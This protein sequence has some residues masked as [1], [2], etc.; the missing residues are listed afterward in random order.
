MTLSETFI[1]RPVATTLL[2]IGVVLSGLAAFYLLPVAPLPQVDFPTVVVNVSLP[3][4]GPDTMAATVATPLERTLG[5]I[6][7]ITEMT[8]V[9]TL[10]STN[11][12]LQF[13]LSRNIDG[14]ARDVQ[15][16]INAARALLPTGLPKNPIYR[17]VNPAD[18]PVMVL[19]LTSATMTQGELYDVA[20]TILAQKISQ[21]NGVG[22]VTV[23]GSA[24][25]AVRVELNPRA[26]NKYGISL[27]QARTSIAATNPNRPKGYLEDDK[28]HWQI[29]ANDQANRAKD[30]MPLVISYH[31]GSPVRLSDVGTAVDSVQDIRNAGSSNGVPAII[32]LVFKQP[33][34]NI[35]ET[36]DNVNKMLPGLRASIPRAV[37]L[38]V[39]MER[40]TTIK[41]ALRDVESNLLVSIF[42]VVL[43]VLVFLRKISSTIIP[44][45]AVP[46]SLI[47]TFGI[48][49]L[50]G[51]SLDNLSLMAIT[52]ATGFVVDDA[53][54]V[55]ENIS[56]HVESGMDTMKAA[57]LGA[58]EV[59]FT[60]VSMSLSL[61]A[62]FIP[63]LFMGG[64][65]GRLFREFA[66]SLSAAILVSLTVSLTLTPMMCAR[67][68][69]RESGEKHGRLY[70]LSERSFNYLYEHY[71]TTL[72]WALSHSRFIMLLLFCTIILN[73]YLYIIVP[74]SF[75]PQQDTGRIIGSIKADQ[76]ISFAAMKKKMDDF[77]R[78]IRQDPAASNVVGIVGGGQQ[79]NNGRIFVSLKPLSERKLHVDQIIARMRSKLAAEPGARLYL[80]ASQDVNMGG[81]QSGAQYQYTLQSDNLNDLREW[82]P[83]IYAAMGTMHELADVNTDQQDNG[84]KTLVVYDRDTIYRLGLTPAMIDSTL[85]DAFG[86]RQIS[87][88]YNPLNQYHVVMEVAPEYSQNA[89]TL[90]DTYMSAAVSS[91]I[92]FS[93]FSTYHETNTPL[94]VNHQGQ[95]A[96]ATIS[97]N[98]PEGGSLSMATDA[99]EKKIRTL[100]V[101]ES[102]H[103]SFQGTAKLFKESFNNQGLLIIA[104]LLTIYI[105]LG[106]LYESYIHPLTILSTLPSAGVG[107]ILTLLIFH[108]DFSLI[109]FIGIIMLI[110]IVKKNA[111]MMIDFAIYVERS[112][113]ISTRDAIYKACLLRFRPIMMTTMAA[114]F[115]VLPIAI[116]SGEGSE[117]RQPLGISI[118]GGLILSQMLT[119]YTTPVVYLYLD[120]LGIWWENRKHA[121]LAR[122]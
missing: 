3:G 122:V 88:I 48:M 66:V 89:Q 78:I 103:G 118:I 70:Q 44:S 77:V 114:M 34:S 86:Q 26:L 63:I 61:I 4:A 115:G 74:K 54:V 64:I 55:L 23:G 91:P 18:S 42:L 113:R 60:V 27:E 59:G 105:V 21:A 65:I 79:S 50:F 111:I 101:P 84:I 120:R 106:V 68:I 9:S 31:N 43:V 51:Y 58:R 52:I 47:G 40:T 69:K 30:Y 62:V 7:G 102:I 96:A 45:I 19:T 90:N 46:V 28:R 109:A 83:K 108:I 10:G 24:L 6:S 85:N 95:F 72:A 39:I 75:M 97:F 92:P 14:A 38:K 56:R 41:S 2:A 81:R 93:A 82:A 5:R 13:D 107:A 37:D 71:K 110:G 73:V 94:A 104:A 32:L 15:A 11:I 29:Y 49:Y 35:I 117:L 25:P 16:G 12:T 8:S 17:K 116:G 76:D 33:G 119:L 57:I 1:K 22:Q 100:G 80:Q 98:L 112:E 87:T 121:R 53:I 99:I 36:I 67:M 20:S